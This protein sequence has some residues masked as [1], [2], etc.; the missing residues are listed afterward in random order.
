MALFGQR[1]PSIFTE[2]RFFVGKEWRMKF[3]DLSF[4]EKLD[5]LEGVAHRALPQWGFPKDSRVRLLNF[6]ENATYLVEPGDGRKVIMRVQRLPYVSIDSIRTELTWMRALREETDL[7]LPEAIPMKDGGLIATIETKELC[8]ERHVVCFTFAEGRP[9]VDSSDGNGD[10]GALIAKIEKIPD[11][12]TIPVF[13]SAAVVSDA[14][15]QHQHG[16]KMQEKDRRIYQMVGS[17]MAKMHVQ[18]LHWK[19]PDFYHRISWD[20]DGTFGRKNNFY[21]TTYADPKWLSARD[22][23]VLNQARETIRC[24]LAL[25]GEG[26]QRYGMI[27]SDLRTANLL[28]DGKTMTVLDFDDCGMGWYMYDIAGAVALMEHRPDLSEIVNEILKGYENI[29]PLEEADKEEI[30]TF[31]MMR[32]IGMLQSLI[33]RIGC[34]MGGSGEACE[35]T[36]EILAFYAKGTVR[37]AE[38]YIEEFSDEKIRSNAI[39]ARQKMQHILTPYVI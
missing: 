19:K 33:C 26:R 31:I 11:S 24:R 13:K 25:Y 17:I 22:I 21:D 18:S 35:L 36:P 29:R 32:R 39:A 1:R 14:I 20:F 30:P 6:T 5:H 4:P 28:F 15:G 9:P 7:S 34:V 3:D 23:E 27:H 37:L 2:G 38:R 8:E 16:S 12:I 10:V